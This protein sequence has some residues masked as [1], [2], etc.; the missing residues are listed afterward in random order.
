M[1]ESVKIAV[2]LPS[3]GLMFSRTAED[4]LKNLKGYDYKIYFAHYRPIPECFNEPLRRALSDDVYTHVWFVED[5]MKM[6]SD[7][8]KTLLEKD[9]A[10]VTADYPVNKDKRGAIF[11]IDNRIIFCGTGCLL[12]RAEVFDE[13]KEPYF[14]T[15]RKWNIKNYGEYFKMTANKNKSI[16][17]YGLHDVNFCMDLYRKDIHIHKVD[18]VLGQ[19][20][21][22]RLGDDGTNNGAHEIEEWNEVEKDQ[23]IK[24]IKSWPVEKSGDLV[25]V[26]MKDGN[27]IQT[28][29]QHAEKLINNKL[30]KKAPKRKLVINWNES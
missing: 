26:I 14:H 9:K 4:L 2:I 30:A 29:K 12:V 21:L 18:K 8:L 11:E 28:S 16:K 23:M 22:K 25:S 5:D 17:G 19:R 15:E 24:K 6:P 27:E 1:K 3:R 20:K 13:L 7:T 10:V